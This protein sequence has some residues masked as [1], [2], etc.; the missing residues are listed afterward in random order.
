MLSTFKFQS[1]WSRNVLSRSRFSQAEKKTNSDIYQ[2]Q[3][4][5]TLSQNR[6]HHVAAI[7]NMQ[8]VQRQYSLERR[9][10]L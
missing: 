8:N 3:N 5:Q 2:S 6:E 7:R 1:I 9:M 10:F 4:K